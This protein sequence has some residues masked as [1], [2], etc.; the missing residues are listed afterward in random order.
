MRSRIIELFL[1][2]QIVYGLLSASSKGMLCS[3]ATTLDCVGGEPSLAER[4][5]YFFLLRIR[6]VVV[7]IMVIVYH[8]SPFSTVTAS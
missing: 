5:E 4:R 6:Q 1:S 8:V 3:V 2:L 7:Q